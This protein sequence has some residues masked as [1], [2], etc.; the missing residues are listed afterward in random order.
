V[1]NKGFVANTQT[2]VMRVFLGFLLAR[3]LGLRKP[4]LHSPCNILKY[5]VSWLGVEIWENGRI[6]FED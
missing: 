4:S 6:K 5:L 2:R 3:A 1:K